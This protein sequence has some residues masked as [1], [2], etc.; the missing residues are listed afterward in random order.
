M[1]ETIPAIALD[2]PM[3]PRPM[4]RV[5]V[6]GGD[7]ALGRAVLRALRE[8]DAASE[9]RVWVSARSA[10]DANLTARLAAGP[11]ATRVVAASMRD[12]AAVA[13]ILE[14]VDVVYH[15]QPPVPARVL[16]HFHASIVLLDA[17]R[18]TRPH[19]VYP[20]LPWTAGMPADG[21]R[22]IRP[23]ARLEP[24]G[25]MARELF[26]IE[27]LFASA[28]EMWN[29]PSTIVRLPDIV[30]P[31]CEMQ[32]WGRLW[33]AARDGRAVQIPFGAHVPR[34]WIHLDDAAR[35][36]VAAGCRGARIRDDISSLLGG[37]ATDTAHWETSMHEIVASGG[38]VDSAHEFA[39]AVT[40]AFAATP[41]AVTGISGAALTAWAIADAGI[42]ALL[43]L[44]RLYGETVRHDG[45]TAAALGYAPRITRD[46]LALG[47][48]DDVV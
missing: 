43:P 26:R 38:G 13:S 30:G 5:A 45:R 34:E 17:A 3:A 44:A 9:I 48:T 36:L 15:C 14:G 37:N 27:R 42:R 23:G 7:S 21:E 20:G 32:P 18:A 8:G 19:I 33:D 35:A 16:G 31:Q 12:H 22:T 40:R 25:H 6:M 2:P 39:C 28:R 4:P 47:H 10:H 46:T 29:V 24:R 1:H 11:I 41:I